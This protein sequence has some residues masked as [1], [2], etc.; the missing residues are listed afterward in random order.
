MKI[1]IDSCSIILL[2]KATVLEALSNKYNL[3]IPEKVYEEILKGKDKNFIDALLTE[4]L[5]KEKKINIKK[6]LNN[7]LKKKLIQDFNL[8]IGEAE[9]LALVMENQC[10]AIITD[11]KQ[12]RKSAAIYGLDLVGSI[13]AVIA[14]YKLHLIDKDKT[15]DG[16]KKL[17][18][19]G[20][21]QDYLIDNALEEVKNE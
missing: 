11:N 7:I 13:D 10:E 3:F 5:V 2:A 16:L 20:W 21:F 6:V 1:A 18:E 15:I 19:F 12:G 9:T 4:R 17:R 8:G 14:L